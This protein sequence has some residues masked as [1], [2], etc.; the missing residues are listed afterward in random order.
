[1]FSKQRQPL[2]WFVETETVIQ[3]KCVESIWQSSIILSFGMPHMEVILY[4]WQQVR[5]FKLL[6]FRCVYVLLCLGKVHAAIADKS[7]IEFG[8]YRCRKMYTGEYLEGFDSTEK[9]GHES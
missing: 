7:S 6:W 9:I 5:K 2:T 4:D 8:H 1:M 3:L